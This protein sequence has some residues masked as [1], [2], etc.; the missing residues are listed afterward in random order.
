MLST[1]RLAVSFFM[2]PPCIGEQRPDWTDGS[3]GGPD[4]AGG[5]S[6]EL[7]KVPVH[8]RLI[9][10]A[11]PGGSVGEGDG[12]RAPLDGGDGSLQ[13]GHPGQVL[14]AD[15]DLRAEGAGEVLPAPADL[16]RQ[17]VDSQGIGAE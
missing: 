10:V 12:G 15:P 2:P 7:A 9:E 3:Q 14:G 4:L 11:G 13:A 17:L 8:V 5:Q 6:D 16:A 1:I